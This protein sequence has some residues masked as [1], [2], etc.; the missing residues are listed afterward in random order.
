VV[1]GRA[2]QIRVRVTGIRHRGVARADGRERG[3]PGKGVIHNGASNGYACHV[4][5]GTSGTGRHRYLFATWRPSPGEQPVA[6]RGTVAYARH[7][8]TDISNRDIGMRYR[9][10]THK[11]YPPGGCR[12]P[13]PDCRP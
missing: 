3:T 8:Y 7:R 12:G 10:D 2:Q 4:P 6:H 11:P 9:L 1:L 13:E 5:Q